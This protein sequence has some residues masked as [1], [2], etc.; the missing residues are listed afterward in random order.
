[1]N[2]EFEELVWNLVRKVYGKRFVKVVELF[3]N[4]FSIEF[5]INKYYTEI[6]YVNNSFDYLDIDQPLIKRLNG[7]SHVSLVF[8]EKYE[9]NYKKG[10]YTYIID[11]NKVEFKWDVYMNFL[12]DGEFL[13]YMWRDKSLFEYLNENY[14]GIHTE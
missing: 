11:Y 7:I 12:K 5:K 9:N 10:I 6:H 13:C 4:R 14:G 1:M 2:N 3:P 8:E